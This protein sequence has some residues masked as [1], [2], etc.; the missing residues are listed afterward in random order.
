MSRARRLWLVIPAVGLLELGA[1]QYFATRA[2]GVEEWEALREPVTRLRQSDE[3]VVVAPRWA[4]P[5]ARRALG[6]QTMPLSD[7]ARPDD[8]G[9]A[10]AIEVSI[11]GERA[12]ELST[13]RTVSEERR[14]RFSLRVLENPSPE[15]VLYDFVDHVSPEHVE[16]SEGAPG[17]P[18][19]CLWRD[20]AP[21]SNGALGGNPTFPKRRFSCSSGDWFFVGVTVIDD[22]QEYR[23]RRCIWSHPTPSGPLR[24]RY[25]SVPLGS[26]IRGYGGMPWL[27]FRDGA[28]EPV[29]LEVRV[30]G[31]SIGTA[32]LRD[33]DGWSGFSFPTGRPGTTADVEFE[34]RSS[35]IKDRHF[36]FSA[37]TR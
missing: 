5:L 22:N 8:S 23:A 15:K 37:D 24:I 2:P 35:N 30:D 26:T 31:Q 18:R 36:C 21:V 29:E 17:M 32:S 3:L 20:N 4:E 27:I 9:R 12:P 10:R 11:L 7:V 1:H 19:P 13:W 33:R 14:G 34:V 28:G 16:V 6:D 25:K